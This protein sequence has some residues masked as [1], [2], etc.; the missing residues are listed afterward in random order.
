M[1]VDLR[2]GDGEGSKINPWKIRGRAGIFALVDGGGGREDLDLVAEGHSETKQDGNG[3]ENGDKNEVGCFHFC[4][5]GD[6][7]SRAGGF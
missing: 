1:T 3:R 5:S 6:G 4:L 2:V 7:V